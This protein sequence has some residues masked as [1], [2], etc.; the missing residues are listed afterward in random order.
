MKYSF[1]IDEKSLF[2]GVENDFFKGHSPTVHTPLNQSKDEN[3]WR[4]DIYDFIKG[5]GGEDI[6]SIPVKLREKCLSKTTSKASCIINKLFVFSKFALD[7]EPFMVDHSFAMCVKEETDETIV[8]RNGKSAE[9]THLGRQTLHYLTALT[10][11]SEGYNIDNKKILKKIL[12]VNGGFAYVVK[13]FDFDTDSK[14]LNFRTTMIGLKGVK[15]SHVF[16]RKKGVGAKLLVDDIRLDNS[17]FTS[18]K[19]SIQTKEENDAFF[20][21]LEKKQE[22]SRSNGLMGE[23]YVYNNLETII[24]AKP[25]N[26]RHISRDYPQSPYD[27]ECK[28]NG[29]TTYIEVKSTEDDKK[30]FFMSRGERKFMDKYE[31]HYFLILV[32]N[33]NSEHRKYTKYQRIDIMN[34]QKM[35]QECQNIKFIVKD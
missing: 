22:T 12:E 23:V 16:K 28:V 8:K 21:T 31:Q 7:G 17:T 24:G 10:Y 20:S 33:V 2:F 1:N 4:N 30:I 27:I 18:T 3:K 32:T 25:E 26:P 34:S 29:E 14:I 11:T 5:Y 6:D 35:D 19:S 13:G 15:L 9:N